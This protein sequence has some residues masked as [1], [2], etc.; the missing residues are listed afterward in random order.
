MKFTEKSTADL[1]IYWDQSGLCCG[2]ENLDYSVT[3]RTFNTLSLLLSSFTEV[4]DRS[5]GGAVVF[6]KNWRDIHRGTRIMMLSV[7]L[8]VSFLS[9]QRI[10][11]KACWHLASTHLQRLHLHQISHCANSNANA[12]AENGSEPIFCVCISVIIK[13]IIKFKLT[14]TLT[15]TETERVSKTLETV[16]EKA[17]VS[18]TLCWLICSQSIR[19]TQSRE[20]QLECTGHEGLRTQHKTNGTNP[21]IERENQEEINSR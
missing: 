17:V 9:L 8:S 13:T 4:K 18:G 20:K 11:F 3:Q 6:V 2:L 21:G 19:E 16:R 15:E 10:V 1:L 12:N 7:C 5:G 14:L